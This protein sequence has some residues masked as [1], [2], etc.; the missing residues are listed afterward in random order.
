MS[1]TKVSTCRCST[2]EALRNM[3]ATGSFVLSVGGC[4]W[5]SI[6]ATA[7]LRHRNY[8]PVIHDASPG[9]WKNTAIA[10][11]EIVPNFAKWLSTG[12]CTSTP[13]AR[14]PTDPNTPNQIPWV[15]P[16]QTCLEPSPARRGSV[17]QPARLKI[18]DVRIQASLICASADENRASPQPLT[19]RAPRGAVLPSTTRNKAGIFGTSTQTGSPTVRLFK[20]DGEETN[21][22]CP[23]TC[24]S[25]RL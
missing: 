6:S 14:I 24:I 12:S 5:R 16:R 15:K 21:S 17:S 8:N 19:P 22:K 9:S 10:M 11:R 7:Q 23:P 3:S 20:V 4:G 1:L 13:D 25:P 18:M 2:L